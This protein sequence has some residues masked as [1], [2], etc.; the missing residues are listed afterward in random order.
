M[1]KFLALAA[2]IVVLVFLIGGNTTPAAAQ[3]GATFKLTLIHTSE[4]HGR[5][6]PEKV[7]EA[8]LGGIARRAT[9]VKK[10]RAEIPNTLLLDSGDISQ[11]TLYFRQY[12]MTEARDFYNLL[13]YD[14]VALGNHEG[15]LG[16]KT[17]ADNF[18]TGAKFDVL[19]A[20]VDFSSSPD[21]VGKIKP[22]VVKTVGIE[23]SATGT[24]G[25]EKIGIFGMVTDDIT[26]NSNLGRTLKVKDAVQ[27]A[28]DMVA[29]FQKQG[30]NKIILLSHRGFDFDRD[31]V[32]KVNGI[33]VIVSGHTATLQGDATK[34]DKALGAPAW[35]YPL[36]FNTPNGG[37]TII[38]HDY[39]FGY[40]LGRAD[41]T[42]DANGDVINWGGHPIN[43]DKNVEEDAAIAAKVAE[44]GK[45]MEAIRKAV[46]AK[47]SVDLVGDR[48]NVRFSETNLGDLVADSMLWATRDDK[49]QVAITN[50]GG[51]RISIKAGDITQ[52]QVLTLLPFGNFL[53]QLDITGADVLAALE[54][55]VSQAHDKSLSG[56]RFSQV[57]GIKF[58]ADLSK[59]VGQ[60]V[61]DVQIGNAATGFKPLDKTATYRIVTIDFMQT[62]GDGYTAFAKG[63][64]VSGLVMT[65]DEAFADYLKANPVVSPKVEGRVNLINVPAAQGTATA[66][67]PTAPPAPPAT[68]TAVP[69]TRVPAPTATPAPPPPPPASDN[70]LLII[71]VVVVIAAG[72]YFLFGRN[73]A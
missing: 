47:S 36:S 15:D 66:V 19:N 58:T 35:P 57:A 10:L 65:N 3:S 18:L 45:P 5:W 4:N 21:L 52:E 69:P 11:G 20:N 41:L 12:K 48:N 8:L 29:D 56:G 40:L 53:V 49:T 32:S 16:P 28:K 23:I 24:F 39:Q 44:L 68:A 51:I 33:D 17:L 27:T 46:V 2:L 63:K 62:G 55:G 31:L 67:P 30:V 60:R 26:I 72:A 50:G 64:N 70:T 25:G 38:V 22:A 37:R 61:T 43:V 9:L 71:V 54:N 7:G 59:P 42:F 73:R 34:L 6:E 13:G 14:A 1:K